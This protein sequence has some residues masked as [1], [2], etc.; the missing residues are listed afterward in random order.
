MRLDNEVV[1]GSVRTE[2]DPISQL[3]RSGSVKAGDLR[4]N[5]IYFFIPPES[6]S[7]IHTEYDQSTFMLREAIPSTVKKGRKKAMINIP[8]A[9]DLND[10][11]M[12]YSQIA[13]FLIQVRKCPIVTLENEKIRKEL[14]GA[15]SDLSSSLA[16]LVENVSARVDR[17]FPSLL[18]IDIQ[19]TW[20]NHHPYSPNIAYKGQPSE[21]EP[22]IS[23]A[24]TKLFEEF[25]RYNTEIDGQ[26]INDPSG[27]SL[28]IDNS[29]D[30][31]YK[32]YR[33]F[34]EAIENVASNSQ[35]KSRMSKRQ[36][37]RKSNITAALQ[38]EGWIPAAEFYGYD[39][40]DDVFYRWRT[41]KVP[42]TAL[43]ESGALI[44][45]D[46]SF[47]LSTNISYLPLQNYSM[48]TAQFMGGSIAQLRAII[49]AAAEYSKDGA[50]I[51][52]S[53]LLA[54]LQKILDKSSENRFRFAKY[55]R[56]DYVMIRHPLAKLLKYKGYTEKRLIKD[57]VFYQDENNPRVDFDYNDML[58]I[59][60]S[61]RVSKTVE[62]HP[63]ASRFQADMKETRLR[64]D[65]DL[66]RIAGDGEDLSRDS[67]RQSWIETLKKVEER[68]QIFGISTEDGPVFQVGSDELN[69]D[70]EIALR[71]ANAMTNMALV[72]EELT[73]VEPMMNSPYFGMDAT[74]LR[75]K[76]KQKAI[77]KALSE[78]DGSNDT[79]GNAARGIV[80]TVN[81][82]IDR[83]IENGGFLNTQGASTMVTDLLKKTTL[84]NNEG[85]AKKYEQVTQPIRNFN[86]IPASLSYPDLELPPFRKSPAYY[87]ADLNNTDQYKLNAI[88]GMNRIAPAVDDA[89]FKQF[90]DPQAANN[91]SPRQLPAN[92]GVSD[93]GN[94]ASF[95]GNEKKHGAIHK[96]SDAQHRA[97]LAAQA[98][99]LATPMTDSLSKAFPAFKIYLKQDNV[100]F[101][102]ELSI[103]DLSARDRREIAQGYRDFS[104]HFDISN[105]IDIRIVK[106]ENVPAD[107]MVLRLVS[108]HK[109]RVNRLKQEMANNK[110]QEDFNFEKVWDMIT[111]RKEKNSITKIERRLKEAGISEGT[112]IQARLG[113]DTNPNDLP[114]E[115]NGKI[116]SV[117]GRDIIEVVCLGNGEELVQEIK[118]VNAGEEYSFNSN[119]PN[120]ISKVL[121]KS[122]E[123]VSFGNINYKS[124]AGI[125][126]PIFPQFLGGR[127]VLDNIF[128]PTLFDSYTQVGVEA[129]DGASFGLSVSATGIGIATLL[130]IATAPALAVLGIG[131]A[132]GAAIYGGA[133][134]YRGVKRW[135][136]G[137]PFTIYNKT[138]WEI[139]Q[140]LTLRHPGTI[141][142]VTPYDNRSTIFFGE[143]NQN[144][145]H[146]GPTP[147]E[148]G[149][150]TEDSFFNNTIRE[151]LDDEILE[152]EDTQLLFGIPSPFSAKSNAG[153]AERQSKRKTIR[154]KTKKANKLSEA[155]VIMNMQKPYRTYHLVSSE[156]DIIANDI[157]VTSR[158]IA[159]S[160]QI[161]FP[162]DADDGNFDGSQGFSNYEL[163]DD[164]QADDDIYKE[165][166]KKKVL[167]FH[168]AHK[169][170]V[171]DMPERYAKSIL[172]R[173]LE[174]VYQGKLTILGRPEMKPHDVCIMRDTYNDIY[175]PVGVSRVTHVISPHGGWVTDIKPK[176]MVF[177]DNASGMYQLSLVVKGAAYWMADEVQLFYTNIRRF[178]PA[179]DGSIDRFRD[180]EA[181]LQYMFGSDY[182]DLED[183]ERLALSNGASIAKEEDGVLGALNTPLGQGAATALVAEGAQ[184]LGTAAAPGLANIAAGGFSEGAGVVT[185][186][187]LTAR[188][189]GGGLAATARAGGA[190]T[191]GIIAGGASAL[192]AVGGIATHILL[193]SAIDGFVN[194]SKYRQ[195]IMFFPLTRSGEPWYAAMNGFKDNTIVSHLENEFNRGLNKLKFYKATAARIWDDFTR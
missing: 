67:L 55:A 75:R 86:H 24:P 190:V 30:F 33:R 53:D 187:L 95:N 59:V 14:L 78:Q 68:Y 54:S 82:S 46:L 172:C 121:E 38:S 181:L 94:L 126:I 179:D 139:L 74:E 116:V 136:F 151:T 192:S 171:D 31:F 61:N 2:S 12:G 182:I 170:S 41:I 69:P 125:E 164:I 120:L 19:M 40:P 162:E 114:V 161:A 22:G 63:F 130:G 105:I 81:S 32:E 108:T 50:P 23:K 89:I 44:L 138:L 159:N 62:G 5:D 143:P 10:D 193:N 154:A 111:E 37:V 129:I 34:P 107:L 175:G 173:E 20:F 178:M 83:K 148:A 180:A 169:D 100:L 72:D 168:N 70:R 128:A 21:G 84:E 48:P 64:E 150:I 110:L 176:M 137:S 142:A 186:R 166:I 117:R 90:Q 141:V 45:E 56:E 13:R 122:P 47:S 65:N 156:H 52:S 101:E 88:K 29:L 51:Q 145:F 9:I 49:F 158:D 39:D 112:R 195:P 119:T 106:D 144:Y 185:S 135:L 146:R 177:P 7:I 104:E 118:G 153:T 109:D 80:T 1:P 131:A 60:V 71:L 124:D 155:D 79:F 167:T 25:Y 93:A 85:W 184:L 16:L 113:Y 97:V 191:K 103:S 163:T 15:G 194:W 36:N 115:F 127:S 42:T 87:F 189:V 8:V 28:L 132:A 92:G 152:L 57:S 18:R 123:V 157:E 66:I 149:I 174:K 160:I 3:R 35:E 140:E 99:S 27:S 102:R 43:N 165:Y 188:T 73:S 11:R 134:V 4:I 17:E 26:L 6:I 147:F 58:P 133:E 96:P 76:A 91:Q 77:A 183:K 98:M